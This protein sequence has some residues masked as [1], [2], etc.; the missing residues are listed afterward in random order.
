MTCLERLAA[1]VAHPA[2]V[3]FDH[4]PDFIP[5]AVADCALRVPVN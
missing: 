2:Y 1:N 4:G 3:R 5:Y